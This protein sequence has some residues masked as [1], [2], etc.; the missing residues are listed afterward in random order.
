M[1][2]PWVQLLAAILLSGCADPDLVD[3]LGPGTELCDHMVLEGAHTYPLEPMSPT[4]GRCALRIV[5]EPTG[6]WVDAFVEPGGPARFDNGDVHLADGTLRPDPP[7]EIAP[8]FVT[9]WTWLHD[10]VRDQAGRDLTR[11]C[12]ALDAARPP[13]A[14]V[15]VPGLLALALVALACWRRG[16]RD[17]LPLL[18][19]AVVLLAAA[20]WPVVHGDSFGSQEVQRLISSLGPVDRI[21]RGEHGDVRQSAGLFL[22]YAPVARIAGSVLALRVLGFLCLCA[23]V[24]AWVLQR[25]R[26]EPGLA[27]SGLLLLLHPMM[28]KN[29]SEVGPF[30]FYASGV[31]L[32]LLASWRPKPAPRGIFAAGLAAQA[33]LAATSQVG[34]AVGAALMLAAV[35]RHAKGLGT[36]KVLLRALMVIVVALPFCLSIWSSLSAEASLREA[37]AQA[38]LLSWGERGLGLIGKGLWASAFPGLVLPLFAVLF[39]ALAPL[40][41][42]K[43]TDGLIL[44]LLGAAVLAGMLLLSPHVRV[45]PYYAL[46]AVP[47]LMLG[48]GCLLDTIPDQGLRLACSTCAVCVMAAGCFSLAPVL[49]RSEPSRLEPVAREASRLAAGCPAL[50]AATHDL[51]VPLVPLL[52]DMPAGLDLE[53]PGPRGWSLAGADLDVVT[54]FPRHG[55]PPDPGSRVR[56][57][58]EEELESGCAQFLYDR[59]FPLPGL[60]MHLVSSCNSVVETVDYQLFTCGAQ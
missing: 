13:L 15:L 57:A 16:A 55:L 1:S 35:M 5:H 43:R 23:A 32:V 36:R 56:E 50:V 51:P 7:D 47:L 38:P 27:L 24:L 10:L 33:F 19:A 49:A 2:R 3:V 14:R 40:G 54:V 26:G 6:S 20:L 9:A 28:L 42:T 22:I 8:A 29:A 48:L 25:F 58:L 46:Y 53:D 45:Q 52:V 18:G 60:Y 4:S 37:A 12:A 41:G 30:A 59:G 21:V 31:L 34:T 39:V 17:G 11:T 44:V